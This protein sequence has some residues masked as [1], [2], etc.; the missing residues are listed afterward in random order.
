M[1]LSE[2]LSLPDE[3]YKLLETVLENVDV[4]LA[5]QL[6]TLLDQTNIIRVP[7]SLELYHEGGLGEVVQPQQLNILLW[8]D[9]YDL[10][11][12]VEAGGGEEIVRII[13]DNVLL[14]V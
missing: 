8:A 11:P 7:S 5:V 1:H 4:F 3:Y 6:Q 13:H 10:H 14:L 9:V 12:Q 2:K